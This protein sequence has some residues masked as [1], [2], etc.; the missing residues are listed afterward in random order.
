MST[1]QR[2][3]EGAPIRT[4]R[5]H[6]ACIGLLNIFRRVSQ[7]AGMSRSF[8]RDEKRRN[9]TPC[10]LDA[11]IRELEMHKLSALHFGLHVY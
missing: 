5:G 9:A 7:T 10:N 4:R 8:R 3:S 6:G 11:R 1:G 2:S